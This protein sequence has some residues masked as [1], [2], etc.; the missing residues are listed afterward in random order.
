MI[1]AESSAKLFW[2]TPT[3]ITRDLCLDYGQGAEVFRKENLDAVIECVRD[4]P[5]PVLDLQR[6]FL[7]AGHQHLVE[8]DGLH[9]NPKGQALILTTLMSALAG[10]LRFP[11]VEEGPDEPQS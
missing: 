9:P 7:T 8:E 6:V 1:S 5:E 10:A 11:M 3:G 2:M 4:R